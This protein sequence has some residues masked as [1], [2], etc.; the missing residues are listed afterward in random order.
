ML[1][2]SLPTILFSFHSHNIKE[3][4]KKSQEQGTPQ[5]IKKF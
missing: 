4:Y 5:A 2:S 1:D 3:K